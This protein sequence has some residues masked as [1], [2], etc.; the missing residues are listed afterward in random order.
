MNYYDY[1]WE[2]E[3]SPLSMRPHSMSG[4]TSRPKRELSSVHL[5]PEVGLILCFADLQVVGS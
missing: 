1:D 3:L 5:E 2:R 4:W